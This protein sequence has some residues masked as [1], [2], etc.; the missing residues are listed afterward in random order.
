MTGVGLIAVGLVA[1]VAGAM[2]AERI[3]YAS[4]HSGVVQQLKAGQQVSIQQFATHPR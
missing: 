1:G 3:Y 2:A 4:Q